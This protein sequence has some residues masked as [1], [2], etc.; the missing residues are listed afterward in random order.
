[1]QGTAAIRASACLDL[2]RHL[3]A[4]QVLREGCAPGFVVTVAEQVSSGCCSARNIGVELLEPEPQL[5]GI[6]PLRAPPELAALKL[7]DDETELLDLPVALL[8]APCEIVH[9]LMKERHIVRQVR[10]IEPHA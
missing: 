3:L 8:H 9:Q 5:I 2:E 7:P 10:E 6:E 1:M 4:Q